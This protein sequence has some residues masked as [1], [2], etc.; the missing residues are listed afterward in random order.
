[1]LKNKKGKNKYQE[2]EGL[3]RAIKILKDFKKKKLP[4]EPIYVS[5][6]K[7]TNNFNFKD[8]DK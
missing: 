8:N 3:Y 6:P 4:R 5:S 2:K 7:I 1:M